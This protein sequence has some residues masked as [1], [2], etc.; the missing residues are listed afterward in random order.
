MHR[1]EGRKV[2]NTELQESQRYGRN[3]DT[4]IN[5]S[6]LNSG[7]FRKKFDQ[8]SDDKNLNRKVYQI[9]KKMLQHRSG[10]HYEDMYW[11]DID[12]LE[13][14]ASETDQK[15]HSKIKYSKATKKSI[16]KYENLLVVHTHP[17]SMPP[18]IN[19]FNSALH[20]KYQICLVCCHDGRIFMYQ[21]NN[22]VIEFFYRTTVA[23]YRKRGFSEFEAQMKALSVFQEDGDIFLKE[24]LA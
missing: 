14:V 21:S 9:V 3:K 10:T 4:T 1:K 23:K 24:V 19:D 17:D 13:I 22:Y 15:S 8:I 5:H 18:S 11:I 7:E 20:N 6:Y 16:A 12:S 2:M